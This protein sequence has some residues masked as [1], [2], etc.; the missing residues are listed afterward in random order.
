MPTLGVTY[1]YRFL[2][3]LRNQPIRP[4]FGLDLVAAQGLPG[5]AG[6]SHRVDSG[7]VFSFAEHSEDAVDADAAAGPDP[8]DP[9][10]ADGG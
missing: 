6:C 5:L 10:G 7:S 4:R 8:P 9:S 3:L 2:F 1:F